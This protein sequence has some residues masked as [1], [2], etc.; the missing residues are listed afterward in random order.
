MTQFQDML[1]LAFLLLDEQ[2]KAV[3]WNPA[4]ETLFGLSDE[5]RGLLA[6]FEP[7]LGL[8]EGPFSLLLP[9]SH[10]E[11]YYRVS[12]LWCGP[13]ERSLLLTFHDQTE[14]VHVLQR[15]HD[16]EE[17]L[18]AIGEATLDAIF[19]MDG[20]G[21]IRY[22][23]AAAERIFGWSAFEM[24]GRDL[25]RF[26]VP[27]R[28]SSGCT[29]DWASEVVAMPRF[30]EVHELPVIRKDGR[31]VEIEL[32]LSDFPATEG[33][34][35]LGV[36]RDITERVLRDRQLREAEAR[37]KFALEG[38]GDGAWDW[39]IGSGQILFS[40]RFKAMLGYD[41]EE[42]D[43]SFAAWEGHIHPDDVQRV[44]RQLSSYLEGRVPTY[45]CDFRMRMKEGDYIWIQDRGLVVERDADGEPIRMVGTQR[46]ISVERQATEALQR[47]LAE[48]MRLNQEL[49]TAQVKLVQSERL[50]A[51][52]Q[53]SAGVAHE[54]NSPLGFVSS[55]FSSLERYARDLLEV[56]TA[57]HKACAGM[58]DEGG[59]LSRARQRYEDA[60]VAYLAEDLPQ[61]FAETR[62]GIDRVQRIVRDL[63]DFSRVGEQEWL[64]ADIHRGIESTLNILRNQLKH[65]V[66]V[67][68]DF[69]KVPE[70]WCI[71]SQLNQVFLNL[72]LN[73]AHAI[74][75]RGTIT[76]RTRMEENNLVVAISDTG[77]GMEASVLARIFEPFYTTKPSGEGTGL[78]LPLTEEIVLRHGGRIRVSSEPG[79]GTTF[80]VELPVTGF[81]D[82][83]A[84][85]SFEQ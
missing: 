5:R 2:R 52:G 24:R 38:A 76:I 23:N 70:I 27:P 1:D 81:S 37:W 33:R 69:G 20:V 18:R 35:A 53:L 65:K 22:V 4:A 67:V 63:R 58:Q 71:P 10:G 59:A 47:Q 60:E 55:N 74:E 44:R 17:Q 31:Q 43:N 36:A 68:K 45:V 84:S 62:D 3:Q 56:V 26:L 8:V 72:F 78:G 82:T 79:V 19:I 41:D 13:E 80:H 75:D 14:Q 46:D 50:A 57:Y 34:A 66:E 42:F 16:S 25:Q 40:Q 28:A 7:V 54:M 6:G 77:R 61:L 73:A 29:P 83:D 64:Y 39:N 11:R 30:G 12:T 21:Q 15:L 85:G 49:E 48:T 51:I 32:S 9:A